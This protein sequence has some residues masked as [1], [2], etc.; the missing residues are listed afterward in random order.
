MPIVSPHPGQVA[1]SGKNG[2]RGGSGNVLVLGQDGEDKLDGDASNDVLFG[3]FDV[4]LVCHS[5]VTTENDL[6]DSRTCAIFVGPSG[7]SP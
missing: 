3:G 7:I 6:D 5:P 1:S 4:D 2:R